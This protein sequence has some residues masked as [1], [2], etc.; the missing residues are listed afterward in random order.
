MPWPMRKKLA[1]F[2]NIAYEQWAPD[3]APGI[4]PMGNPLPPGIVDTQARSWGRYGRVG[5]IRLL[6][7]LERTGLP[8]TIMASGSF[9]QDTPD[10]L[11]EMVRQGHE[12]CGHSTYQNVLPALLSPQEERAMIHE[13]QDAIGAV[14]GVRPVGWISP[15]GTPS[16][17]TAELLAE[18]G[19]TWFG[20]CFDA[21]RGQVVTHP[22][23]PLVHLPLT[24]EINDLPM[25]MKHGASPSE[26]LAA[27][28]EHLAGHLRYGDGTSHLDVTVH[29]HVG[30]RPG[31]AAAFEDALAMLAERD[32]VWIGTRA[33]AAEMILETFTEEARHR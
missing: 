14:T 15:R 23:G 4:S 29:A 22:A 32:D 26:Y 9:A 11:Q 8:A 12:I 24:M 19:G 1:V 6:N 25:V 31:Y 28:N 2:V 18:A 7:V 16:A 27:M 30:G 3:S 13:C 5:I 17:R 20:D 21:D 10:V 33:E